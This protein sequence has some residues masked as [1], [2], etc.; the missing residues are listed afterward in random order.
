VAGIPG[1][2]NMLGC[3]RPSKAPAAEKWHAG[4]QE[5]ALRPASLSAIDRVVATVAPVCEAAG[6]FGAV[7]RYQVL[8][9]GMLNFLMLHYRLSGNGKLTFGH[10]AY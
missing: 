4:G 9:S 6:A 8:W 10:I 7:L 2:N 3:G 1:D 5:E